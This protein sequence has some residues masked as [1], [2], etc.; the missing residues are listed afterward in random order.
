MACFTSVTKR[1]DDRNGIL[2]VISNFF[3]FTDAITLEKKLTITR[4]K[5]SSCEV[6]VRCVT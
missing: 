3:L 6:I 5:N 4:D 1:L 2:D